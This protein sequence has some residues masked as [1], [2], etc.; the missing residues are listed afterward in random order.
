MPRMRRRDGVRVRP[1]LV[2]SVV[3]MLV[4]GF[5]LSPTR[6]TPLPNPH[7]ANLSN[8]AQTDGCAACHRVHSD[9]RETFVKRN[10]VSHAV[11][12]LTCHDSTGSGTDV[13]AQF[14]AAGTNDAASRS[15]FT[16]DALATNTMHLAI[17]ADAEGAV[18]VPEEF[19]GVLNR[20]AD[21]VDCHN[22]H[23]STATPSSVAAP[24]GWTA[25]GALLGIP[26]V[27]AAWQVTPTPTVTYSFIA[28][29]TAATPEYQLCLKCHSGYT[30]LDNAGFTGSPSK[31]WLDKGQDVNPANDSMHPISGPGTNQSTAMAN[32]LAGGTNVGSGAGQWD[33]STSSTVSCTMCHGSSASRGDAHASANRGI[34]RAKYRDRVLMAPGEAF[35][36]SDFAL[37]W[38]CH[39]SDPFTLTKD[40]SGN[41]PSPDPSTDAT[42]FGYLHTFHMGAIPSP[43]PT[44]GASTDIDMS[45]A[46]EG[47]ALCSECHFRLHSTAS[48]VGD[49]DLNSGDRTR[50]VNFAPDVQPNP[51]GTPIT[52]VMRNGSTQGYC[53]LTCH[54]HLH[55]S[56]NSS[57]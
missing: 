28:R 51:G 56:A 26:V 12:C 41:W 23:A 43:S 17:S 55:T 18:V 15:Y 52:W 20:H 2:G 38:Q 49:Q 53:A 47:N 34:L 1:R 27:E 42:N 22:P 21:C 31:M 50:L 48:V 9:K 32:S 54:G 24:G 7:L 36:T 29:A 30:V 8:L 3:L 11:D 25:S 16:H 39:S 33:L 44:L 6:A 4:L 5:P 10:S 13:S 46:G 19:S 37:C 45:G 35:A 40:G 14:S 57:Y